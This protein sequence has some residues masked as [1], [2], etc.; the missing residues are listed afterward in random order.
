MSDDSDLERSEPAS[1]RRLE[2]AREEGDVPRSRELVTC[3]VLLTAGG[4]FW[5][6]GAHIASQLQ[7]ALQEGLQF[8]TQDLSNP[9]HWMLSVLAKASSAFGV[10]IPFLC[11]MAIAITLASLLTGGWLLSAEAMQFNVS[12]LNP[13]RGLA[14]MFSLH[15]LIELAKSLAKTILV[16]GVAAWVVWHQKEAIVLLAGSFVQKASQDASILLLQSFIWVASSLILIALFD[17]PY[18]FW[19]HAK[20]LRMTRDELRREMIEAEGHPQLRARIRAQRAQMARRRMMEKIPTAD[21]VVTNP[22]HY[23]VALKYDEQSMRA[24]RVVAKGLGE[25]ALKIRERAQEHS[26]P[27]LEA[28]PLAR[29]LYH[30]TELDDEIPSPLY[31]AVAE[32]LAYILQLR[33]FQKQGGDTPVLPSEWD[34]PEDWDKEKGLNTH[35]E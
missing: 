25:V 15:S 17:V 1:Q 13:L 23:S 28:P 3:V 34:I 33:Q 29:A 32:L 16:G 12:R 4:F 24:P 6:A 19:H 7:L 30:H 10:L 18:Q 31:K 14:N 8:S 9:T 11:V 2:S 21:V 20:R 22:T 26:V 5:F 27:L 35:V